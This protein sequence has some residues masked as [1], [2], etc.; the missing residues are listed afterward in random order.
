MRLFQFSRCK[1]MAA[2]TKVV[3]VKVVGNI[4]SGYFLGDDFSMIPKLHWPLV[5]CDESLSLAYQV[6]FTN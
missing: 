1:K 3:T 4:N 2:W 5:Q 6:Y